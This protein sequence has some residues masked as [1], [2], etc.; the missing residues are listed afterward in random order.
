[1]ALFA[2]DSISSWPDGEDPASPLCDATICV[3]WA[4]PGS[5]APPATDTSPADGIPDWVATVL[6]TAEQVWNTEI[7]VVWTPRCRRSE[8]VAR[9]PGFVR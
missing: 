1:M 4:A 6:Q 5:D 8:A 9:P 3:H 7:A 2:W